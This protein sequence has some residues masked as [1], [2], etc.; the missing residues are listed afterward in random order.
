MT[1][2][3][4]AYLSP[5]QLAGESNADERSDIYS[6]G[7]IVFEALAGEPP[8]G[9]T[10]L[11]TVLSRKLTQAAPAVS[12]LRESVPPELDRFVACCLARL[13]ADRYQRATEA[14]EA[15]RATP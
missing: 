6:L 13:P 14:R 7:C 9:D 8:F 12:S 2:G 5:E 15:L 10:N 3:A 1:I 11:A 4:P